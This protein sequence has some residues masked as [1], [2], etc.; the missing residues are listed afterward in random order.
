[1]EDG[2]YIEIKGYMNEQNNAKI[3]NFNKPLKVLLKTNIQYMLDY[4]ISKYGK[5]F[6]NLY[7]KQ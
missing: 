4:V 3:S 7:E 6:I 2:S 5:K 1:M